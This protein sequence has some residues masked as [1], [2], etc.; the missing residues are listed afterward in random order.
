MRLLSLGREFGGWYVLEDQFVAYVGDPDFHDG[1]IEGVR[2]ESN[3]VLVEIRGNRGQRFTVEFDEVESTVS[4]R[5]E[6]MKVY[7]MTEMKMKPPMRKLVFTN[8]DEEDGASLEVVAR[9]FRVI[10]Q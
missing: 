3:K 2:Y 7:S 10:R 4:N 9:D 6:G 8:W 1:T 5:P